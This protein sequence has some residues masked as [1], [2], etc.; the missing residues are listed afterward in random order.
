MKTFHRVT[1]MA[2][3]MLLAVAA[4]ASPA[5]TYPSKPVR[6]LIPLPAGGAV[7]MVARTTGTAV[8]ERTRM[9]FVYE[10][11]PGANTILSTDACAKAPPD[12]HTVCLITS[13]ISLNP[14]LYSKL[15]FDPVKD[16]EPITTLVFNYEALLLNPSVPAGNVREL[17]AYAKA[18][19]GKINFGSV[20]T[21]S[22]THLVPEWVSQQTGASFTHIPYKGIGEVVRAFMAGDI[23]MMFSSLGNPGFI[24]NIKSGKMKALFVQTSRRVP[25]IPDVPTMAE[26]GVPDHGYRSWWGLAAP[27]HTPQ[28]IIQKLYADFSEALR[29]S[30]VRERFA[31]LNVEPVGNNPEQFARFMAEDRA[32]AERLVKASGA[33]LD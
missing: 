12:G 26:A 27:A 17:V 20:G 14:F 28:D 19:P 10:N 6:F 11:R 16:I 13:S 23:H 31:A 22:P 33:R 21:G 2:L 9:Q 32:G 8:T 18:N 3:A 4:A 25:L 15:P 30:A 29:A 1:R 7:D 5:Q 24:A